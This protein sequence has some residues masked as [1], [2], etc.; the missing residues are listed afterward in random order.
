MYAIFLLQQLDCIRDIFPR[1]KLMLQ[2]NRRFHLKRTRR[3]VVLSSDSDSSDDEA[4]RLVFRG[5]NGPLT[6][7]D[8]VV[9]EESTVPSHGKVDLEYALILFIIQKICD[10][11][12]FM[13]RDSRLEMEIHRLRDVTD[14]MLTEMMK[15]ALCLDKYKL[16][17][18]IKSG[19]TEI[20]FTKAIVT[21]VRL[22]LPNRYMQLDGKD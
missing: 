19:D 15:A 1:I 12:S 11:R 13:A 4:T 14:F 21:G 22:N 5:G 10:W 7:V 20:P 17:C 2:E 8:E 3:R 18:N 16:N 6:K 9:L